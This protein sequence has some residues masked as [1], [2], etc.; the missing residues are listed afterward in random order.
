MKPIWRP[1]RRCSTCPTKGHKQDEIELHLVI[2][3]PQIIA[4]NYSIN[5][6]AVDGITRLKPNDL[7]PKIHFGMSGISSGGP[8]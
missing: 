1:H 2:R 5:A 3:E 6:I 4:S 8:I 7:K